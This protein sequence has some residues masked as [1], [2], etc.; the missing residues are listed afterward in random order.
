MVVHL[1]LFSWKD[2]V[3]QKEIND[4]MGSIRE[5]KNKI[6]Y[7]IE[8]YAGE[9]FSKWN[10]GYTHAVVV[11]TK[12]RSGLDCYRNHP[13]HVPIANLVDSMKEK[14]IGIDFEQ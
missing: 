5:L 11:T 12:D 4:L 8:L 1:A 10:E 3:S 13:S 14:A 6:P 9:N 2:S 7:I